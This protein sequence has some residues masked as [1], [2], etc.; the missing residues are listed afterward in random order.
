VRMRRTDLRRDATMILMALGLAVL[1]PPGVAVADEAGEARARQE[2]AFREE[3]VPLL[4]RYCVRCHSGEMVKG[5]VDFGSYTDLEGVV[6]DRK[7]W[8]KVVENVEAGIMPPE[9]DMP[10]EAEVGR[11]VGWVQ[12]TLSQDGCD[13][14]DPGRV[15]LRRLNRAE[16]NNT[17]RDLL[18]VEF[19]PADNF[20]MDDVGYG[21]DNIGDVLTLPP[22]LMEKYLDAAEKIA[23]EA[24]AVP[25]PNPGT[26]REVEGG[27]LDG[28]ERYEGS[29][30]VLSANGE[31][32]ASFGLPE[33]GR[34]RIV[35]R[36]FGD[37]AGDEPVKLAVRLDGKEIQAFEVRGTRGQAETLEVPVEIDAGERRVSVAFLN[38][39]FE[40]KGGEPRDR[41]LIVERLVVEG[42]AGPPLWTLADL[43]GR[44]LEGGS[45]SG[46]AR[47]LASSGEIWAEV[48]A[49]AEGTYHLMV[50]AFGDQA[51]PEPVKIGVRV[52]GEEVGILEV[53]ADESNPGTYEIDARIPEGKHKIA[54]AFLNDYYKPDA[55]DEK[56]RGDRNLHVLGLLVLATQPGDLPE[57][58]RRI[59]TRTPQEGQ[60]WDDAARACLKPFLERAYRRPVR[61]QEL[62][63]LLRLVE[64]ARANG[65]PF[66]RGIQL[67]VTAALVNPHFLYRVE[68]DR[69]FG[70]NQDAGPIRP[71][72]DWELATRLSYFLWSSMPDEELFGLA[73]EGKLQDD[74]VLEAQARRMLADPRSRALV[75]NFAT[76]W[77]TLRN[78]A[79]I[80]PDPR[81]FR[82]FDGRLREAMVEETT[83]FF[84]TI[85]R[86]DRSILEFLDA[87]YTFLNETLAKHYG[88]EGVAGQEFRRVSLPEESPRGGVLTQA[89]ILTITS[90]PTRTS[91]VKRGKWILEQI[92]GTPP[93]PPPPDVPELKEGDQ[94]QGTLRERMEQHRENPSCAVC[95][96]KM[97]PLGFGFENFDAVGRWRDEDNGDPIDPSGK[98]PSGEEFAG[99]EELKQMLKTRRAEPFTRNLAEK[100]LT[101]ALG[102]G[103][104]YY[105]ACAVDTIA[106]NVA[107]D[108]H[109][110]SRLVVEVVKS[111]PFRKRKRDEGRER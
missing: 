79:G 47:S 104:E 43:D 105:D 36:A 74:A 4:E 71:L 32:A 82:R 55:E 110:F 69:R 111:D 22:L 11:I 84:E 103:L 63:P 60:G 31:V 56:D 98:L 94:L 7:V 18:G 8:E 109:R 64:L 5:K 87:D 33:K 95:H 17:V 61:D 27:S 78:V 45:R 42:P 83:R 16:Y 26:R 48:E 81:K 86:E 76:Q 46:R 30:R 92:L 73:R 29:A 89:S 108:G 38:D 14:A 77:L 58:H 28:G 88:I 40:E 41:N 101:Y 75:D 80:N 54:L 72:N 24:I 100:M 19:R 51:G 20:P 67:A 12:G 68:V 10:T 23:G 57:A 37:Q 21:F 25:R 99:V 106:A 9:G 65:E 97:D 1:V 90:N 62:G 59:V 6:R 85:M 2:R 13:I 96:E 44:K 91:P 107:A 50:R 52:D 70:R 49:P 39:F 35:V 102:R 66:E 34:Y 3:V 93:P 15:T 53:P